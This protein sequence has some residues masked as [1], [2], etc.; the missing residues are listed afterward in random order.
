MCGLCVLFWPKHLWNEPLGQSEKSDYRLSP[1][2][3]T[4]NELF[5]ILLDVIM[6]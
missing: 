6:A 3:G 1:V 2:L 4:I 5:L